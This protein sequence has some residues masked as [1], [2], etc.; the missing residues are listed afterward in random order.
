[1]NSKNMIVTYEKE[2]KKRHT[3]IFFYIHSV[4]HE[5]TF[6]YFSARHNYEGQENLQQC[7]KRC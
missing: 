6:I 4:T 1:M 3:D 2:E 7:I 5:H